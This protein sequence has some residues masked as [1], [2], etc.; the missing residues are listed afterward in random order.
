MDL[1]GD[2]ISAIATAAGGGL[3]GLVGALL[4]VGAKMLQSWEER[5]LLREKIEGRKIEQAHELKLLEMQIARGKAETE[6][7]LAIIDAAA[8]RDV[9]LASYQDAANIGP[10]HMWVSDVLRLFRPFLTIA[11]I[12]VTVWLFHRLIKGGGLPYIS[13][14]ELVQY[15]VLSVVFSA[16]AAVT[17]WFG[18]RAMMPDFKK[19]GR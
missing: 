12:G 2:A 3:F 5:K 14:P 1:A 6:S 11:L 8:A 9:K 7:E 13:T 16:T 15:I 4:G 19:G 17:W 18:E 10:T